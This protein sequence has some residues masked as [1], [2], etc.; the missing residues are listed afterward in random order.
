MTDPDI[1]PPDESPATWENVVVGKV[2]EVVGRITGDDSL[3]HE[4]HDQE[5]AAHEVR[6]EFDDERDS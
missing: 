5:D 1:E 2:K 4:G 6:H 3:S